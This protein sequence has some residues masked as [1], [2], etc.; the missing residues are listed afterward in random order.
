MKDAEAGKR[1][2]RE[3]NEAEP[4]IQQQGWERA[5]RPERALCGWGRPWRGGHR[6]ARDQLLAPIQGHLP[7]AHIFLSSDS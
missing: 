3:E 2:T 1:Q 4:E 5:Q 6:E 7:T